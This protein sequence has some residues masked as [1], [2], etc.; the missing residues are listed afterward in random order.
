M[1][2]T[3]R[4]MQDYTVPCMMHIDTHTICGIDS[5][6]VPAMFQIRGSPHRYDGGQG[7]VGCNG[8]VRRITSNKPDMR[9]RDHRTCKRHALEY[10]AA[11]VR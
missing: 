3:D 1:L 8:L 2:P 11:K 5:A 4:V 7:P 6:D 9:N 10:A